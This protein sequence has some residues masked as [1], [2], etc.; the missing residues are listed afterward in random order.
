M[1]FFRFNIDKIVK[2]TEIFSLKLGIN[3][4]FSRF[5]ISLE[6]SILLFYILFL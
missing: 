1:I 2:N 4:T 5:E 3:I 6:L